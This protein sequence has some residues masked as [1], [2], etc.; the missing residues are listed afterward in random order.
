M[1]VS[2]KIK[3]SV[4]WA[5]QRVETLNDNSYD[6]LIISLHEKCQESLFLYDS[7]IDAQT[8][9]FLSAKVIW[10]VDIL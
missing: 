4:A 2:G 6:F 1:N 9:P 3:S 7:E 10:Y 5:C 8:V